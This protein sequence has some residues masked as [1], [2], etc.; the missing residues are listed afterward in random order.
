M[1]LRASVRHTE[2]SSTRLGASVDV[3]DARKVLPSESGNVSKLLRTPLRCSTDR[4]K[5]RETSKTTY[6]RT[7]GRAEDARSAQTDRIAENQEARRPRTGRSETQG[8]PAH[9]IL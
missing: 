9:A 1:I 4:V 5:R 6:A 3:T 2:A 7:P 8:V